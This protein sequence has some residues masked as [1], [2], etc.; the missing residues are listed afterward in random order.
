VTSLFDSDELLRSANPVDEAML[1]APS[2]SASAQRLFEK[3]TGI[4]YQPAGLPPHRHRWRAYVTSMVAA[5]AIGGGVAYAVTY[6]QPTKRLNVGCYAQA[7][8]QGRIVAVPSHG[9]DPVAACRNAW[10]AGQIGPG[11]PPP[12]LV[13][14]ILPSGQAGVF[15]AAAAD[16][17]VCGRLGLAPVGGP[18]PLGST[19]VP[20]VF[21]MRDRVVAA[22][23]RSCLSGQQAVDLVESE[24]RRAGLSGWTVTTT[25]PFTPGRP[26]A[27]PGFDEPGQRVLIV[28]IPPP[29]QG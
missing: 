2:E 24:L 23:Q 26:C 19:S 10:T 14:C 29:A 1:S 7:S 3:I 8:R 13:A 17:D 11:G 12:S 5:V 15:P 6:R 22:L 9:N 20:A 27:S 28:P 16:D 25:T 18:S 21:A 4:S